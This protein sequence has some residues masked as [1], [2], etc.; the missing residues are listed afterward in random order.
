MRIRSLLIDGQFAETAIVADYRSSFA[1]QGKQ[2]SVLRFRLQ[3][4]NGRYRFPLV[5][6]SICGIPETW[7]HG[8]L[9]T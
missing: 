8:N 6:F 5:P 3:Q 2:T 4:T 1:D 7:R 9:E